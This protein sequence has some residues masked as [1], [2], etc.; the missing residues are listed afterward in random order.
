MAPTSHVKVGVAA[1]WHW[2]TLWLWALAPQLANADACTQDTG[3][4]A[5]TREQE[6]G[7]SAACAG[8][9]LVGWCHEPGRRDTR[10]SHVRMVDG[11]C[12]RRASGGWWLG[13][14]A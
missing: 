14:D 11:C 8:G 7:R 9:S 6:A 13:T 5:Y 1:G 4:A 3:S 12:R 2:P 10:H